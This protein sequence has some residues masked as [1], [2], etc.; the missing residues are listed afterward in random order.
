MAGSLEK[1]FQVKSEKTEQ[2]QFSLRQIMPGFQVC[3][4]GMRKGIA[5]VSGL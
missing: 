2:M 1:C 3:T 5:G 4:G